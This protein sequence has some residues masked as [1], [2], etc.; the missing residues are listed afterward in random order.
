[1]VPITEVRSRPS[2]DVAAAASMI[3]AS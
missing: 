3:G 2:I 1:V